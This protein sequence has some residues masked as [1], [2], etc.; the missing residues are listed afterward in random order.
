MIH[1]TRS[2]SARCLKHLARHNRPSEPEST[3]RPMPPAA[4]R[5]NHCRSW[6]CRSAW[7]WDAGIMVRD[8]GVLGY[9]PIDVVEGHAGTP[10]SPS[11]GAS[12]GGSSTVRSDSFP[13]GDESVDA[14]QP[15]TRTKSTTNPRPGPRDFL[16]ALRRYLSL[17]RFPS[18]QLIPA[19][20]HLGYSRNAQRITR[21]P[22]LDTEHPPPPGNRQIGRTPRPIG[23]G[24]RFR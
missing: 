1:R 8:L 7:L 3:T 24:Q 14:A 19:T 6:R 16:M 21:G 11:S 13:R 15:P 2:E 9:V 22:R 20:Q 23:G 18:R 4:I 10:G 12:A 17:T 5:C